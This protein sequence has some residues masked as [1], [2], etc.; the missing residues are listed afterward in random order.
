MERNGQTA[1]E[2][3]VAAS[4]LKLLGHDACFIGDDI[5]VKYGKDTDLIT[6]ERNGH[7]MATSRVSLFSPL[8]VK[9]DVT[10]R[11]SSCSKN[12]CVYIPGEHSIVLASLLSGAWSSLSL[13]IPISI[14]SATPC[15]LH[16]TVL[17]G[18]EN[19]L[20]LCADCAVIASI[21]LPFSPSF[22]A[23][24]EDGGLIAVSNN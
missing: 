24:S 21:G 7:I 19:A 6:A 12:I 10:L 11:S 4:N 20:A 13:M 14:M 8:F 16:N 15:V 23:C 5:V 18:T 22:V 2:A 1:A 9:Q 3:V 17:V